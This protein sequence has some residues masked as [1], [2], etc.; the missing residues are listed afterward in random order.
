MPDRRESANAKIRTEWTVFDEGCL[1]SDV[2]HLS[3]SAHS[4]WSE[5]VFLVCSG[6]L[7]ILDGLSVDASKVEIAGQFASFIYVCLRIS[8]F[9]D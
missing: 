2:Y 4:L 1:K 6:T 8:L 3:A 9:K 5:Q 7:E